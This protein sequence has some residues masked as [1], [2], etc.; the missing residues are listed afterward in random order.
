MILEKA[1]DDISLVY[2]Q[3]KSAI[4]FE[5]VSTPLHTFESMSDSPKMDVYEIEDDV[6]KSF[7]EFAFA[8]KI[9][10][11]MAEGYAAEVAAKMTAMDNATRNAGWFSFLFFS[12]S[13]SISPL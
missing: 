13:S 12:F 9:F 7:Q 3:F 1:H 2:N 11:S 5:T 8:N 6:L 10:H 4:A